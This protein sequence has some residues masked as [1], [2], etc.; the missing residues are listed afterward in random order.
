MFNRTI[1]SLT[2]PIL[3]AG[4][5][6]LANESIDQCHAKKYARYIE[7]HRQWV[8]GLTDLTI[9]TVPELKHEAK[10]IQD[11]ELLSIE[12]RSL[13]FS[14]LLEHAPNKLQFDKPVH[15]WLKL[16]DT[17]KNAIAKTDYRY[18]DLHKQETLK[19]EEEIRL[20]ALRQRVASKVLQ[21]Q[22]FADMAMVNKEKLSTI[23]SV[24]CNK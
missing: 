3:L 22:T 24:L 23:N 4:H 7:A 18:R 5:L 8:N 11:H 20:R 1:I 10:L 15:L 19:K 12:A 17:E 6:A 9:N 14:Y 2:L 16:S 21:S 13:E